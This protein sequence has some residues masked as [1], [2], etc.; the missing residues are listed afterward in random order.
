MCRD[1]DVCALRRKFVP[2][3]SILKEKKRKERLRR[4]QYT[5]CNNKGKGDTLA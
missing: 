5:P 3:Q 4:Q 2:I 1:A